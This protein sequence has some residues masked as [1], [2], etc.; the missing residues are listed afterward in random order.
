M[1]SDQERDI[2]RGKKL[3]H[4]SLGL[5]DR[6]G[7]AVC[8]FHLWDTWREAFDPDSLQD[9]FQEIAICYPGVKAAVENVPTH[10]DSFTPFDL[11]KRF[12]WITLDL[13]WAALYDELGR[14][15]PLQDRIANVHLRGTLVSDR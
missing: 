11:V 12:R 6:L 15:E 9:V 3:I 10:L 8:V 2:D 1:C 13:R 7:A 14:F 5:A 4:E